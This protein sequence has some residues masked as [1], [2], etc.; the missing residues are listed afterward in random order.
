MQC[1]R[2]YEPVGSSSSA[3][4]AAAAAQ[5]QQRQQ[6]QRGG[7]WMIMDTPLA[8]T[9]GTTL[10]RI[11]LGATSSTGSQN[12]RV[13]QLYSKGPVL[14]A[15]VGSTTT[16]EVSIQLYQEYFEYTKYPE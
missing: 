11:E 6:Q 2:K 13:L 9:A 15:N 1:A 16:T 14:S 5:Q 8:L 3:A 12:H 4:A 10:A 7:A